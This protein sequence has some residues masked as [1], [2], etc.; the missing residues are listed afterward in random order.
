MLAYAMIAK[1]SVVR[2]SFCFPK[3][4]ENVIKMHFIL[5]E[6]VK[7]IF[8]KSQLLSKIVATFMSK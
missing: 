3:S 8:V 4:K 6:L 2:S 5:F 1:K 7:L